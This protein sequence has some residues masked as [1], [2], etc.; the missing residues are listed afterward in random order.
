MQKEIEINTVSSPAKTLFGHPTG[1]YLLFFTEMWERFSYYGMRALLL[2]YMMKGFLGYTDNKAYTIYA[3]YTALVYTTPFIGGIIAD[4]ILGAKKSVIFGGLLMGIGQILMMFQD[5][6][7][8]FLALAFIIC[9]N[10]FFKPNISTMVGSLYPEGSSKRDQ[11]FTIFYMGINLGAALA[12]LICGYIGETYGWHLGFGLASLGMLIGLAVFILPELLTK[13]LILGGALSTSAVMIYFQIQEGNLVLLAVNGFV[14]LALMVSGW[15]AFRALSI[16]T[17]AKDIGAPKDPSLLQKESIVKIINYEAFV[18]LS[19]LLIVPMIAV[20]IKFP[21]MASLLLSISGGAAF[22]YL[23]YIAISSSKI[24]KERLFVVFVMM[25]FSMLFW[26]F[27]EQAGTSIN[28][29]TDRNVNRVTAS[30]STI[31]SEQVGQIVPIE[32]SQAH[33]GY[34]I[35]GKVFTLD[36]LDALKAKAKDNPSNQNLMVDLKVTPKNVGMILGGSEV[37]ASTFQSTNPIYILLFGLAFSALWA[38]LASKKLDPSTPIKFV[39]AL[40][41]LGLGFWALILGAKTA[42]SQGMVNIS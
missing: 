38:F 33:L 24:E 20:L 27:F 17:L 34:P 3:A 21:S 8:F 42:D 9:G 30:T 40:V 11:G 28:N 18:Y 39:L 22:L 36:Q 31:T 23:F 16:Q 15:I 13:I 37:T 7:I 32:L 29:F 14:G 1:L 12:P 5:E 19:A 6:N 25:F 41:Q 26:A 35:N 4:R 10:G 2:Y